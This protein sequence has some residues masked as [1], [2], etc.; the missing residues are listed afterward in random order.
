MKISNLLLSSAIMLAVAFPAFANEKT[1]TKTEDG[2]SISRTIETKKGMV[3]IRNDIKKTGDGT[4]SGERTITNPDGTTRT[5]NTKGTKTESGVHKEQ[6]WTG[7]DGTTKTRTVD[8]NKNE[9]GTYTRSVKG[10]N[11]TEHSSTGNTRKEANKKMREER[12]EKRKEHNKN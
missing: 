12:K 6:T 4:W 10:A 5:I 11:G 7:K 1:V 9:D 3:S 2:R 8:V